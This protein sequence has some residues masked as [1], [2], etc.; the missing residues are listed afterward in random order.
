MMVGRQQGEQSYQSSPRTASC[1]HPGASCTCNLQGNTCLG[2]HMMVGRQQGEQSY[3]SSPRTA[4]C[5][6][7]GASCT[8]NLQGNT[9][10]H[11]ILGRELGCKAQEAHC[12]PSHGTAPW[13][14]WNLQGNTRRHMIFAREL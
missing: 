5:L 12:Y 7:P 10:R 9:R 14:T 1:L 6:H 3:Q 11:M 2:L 13:S 8:C 4:S